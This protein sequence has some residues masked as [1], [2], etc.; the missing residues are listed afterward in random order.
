MALTSQIILNGQVGL[1]PT[2]QQ[3]AASGKSFTI[4]N[5][6]AGTAIA[7]AL[8]A[9]FSATANG[10]FLI[11]NTNPSGGASIY[12]DR[13]KLIQT[14]TAPTGTLVMR[15]EAFNESGIVTATGNVATRT[16]VNVNGS[17][18]NSTGAVVQSFAAGAMTI[19]AAVGTRRLVDIGALQTGVAI[20]Q[21]AYVMD[22]GADGVSAGAEGLTAARAAQPAR[23]TGQ[24]AAI[25]VAPQNTVWLNMWWLTAAA[26]VPSFEFSLVYNEL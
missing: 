4:T 1:Q 13:L 14:A 7:Y 24:M 18:G 25:V 2:R 26:N 19:P 3:L 21:D 15:F 20:A 16:P 6:T 8:Q 5:P 22:F 23:V 17:F 9:T 11:Q 10:L 12:L